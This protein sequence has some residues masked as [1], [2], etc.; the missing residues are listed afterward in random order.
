M[1]NPS[2]YEERIADR[3]APFL[4]LQVFTKIPLT[5]ESLGKYKIGPRVKRVSEKSSNARASLHSHCSLA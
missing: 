3:L 4:L 1:L 5:S 2:S